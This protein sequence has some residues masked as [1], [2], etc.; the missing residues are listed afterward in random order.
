LAKEPCG[1]DGHVGSELEKM[2]GAVIEVKL[3]GRA[4]TKEQRLEIFEGRMKRPGSFFRG[5]MMN[6]RNKGY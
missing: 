4:L 1:S 2:L 5:L 3:T 6:M